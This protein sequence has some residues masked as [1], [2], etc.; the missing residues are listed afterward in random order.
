M[1]LTVPLINSEETNNYSEPYGNLV[2]EIST[3]GFSVGQ[4][5]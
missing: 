3:S 2:S 5:I 1:Y 4:N